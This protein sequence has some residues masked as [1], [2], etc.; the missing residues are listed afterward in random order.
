MFMIEGE[1][2]GY[3][4]SQQ[5][6]VHR[7]YVPKK[8]AGFVE[9]V[10]AIG[11]AIYFSDGTALMIHVSEVARKALPVINGYTDLIRKCAYAGVDSVDKLNSTTS[12]EAKPC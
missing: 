10:K 5:R 11:Y 4:S 8:R 1:W 3:R 6:V 2:T 12:G 9:K 7:E